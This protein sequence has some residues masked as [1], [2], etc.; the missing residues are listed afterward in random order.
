M[1]VKICQNAA[2]MPVLM[3]LARN[4]LYFKRTWSPQR[5]M[6]GPVRDI[7]T[8]S[9]KSTQESKAALEDDGNKARLFRLQLDLMKTDLQPDTVQAILLE[10]LG[11]SSPK[12][13][14]KCNFC[15]K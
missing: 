10:A 15:S 5:D 7:I 4:F 2:T 8:S 9:P 13:E 12:S 1:C 3:W 6:S 11:K 14:K